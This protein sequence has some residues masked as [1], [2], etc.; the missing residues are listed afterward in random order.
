MYN[1]MNPFLENR[2]NNYVPIHQLFGF[3]SQNNYVE[4]NTFLLNTKKD[5]RHY[6]ETIKHSL[7]VSLETLQ[8]NSLSDYIDMI[9]NEEMEALRNMLPELD[10]RTKEKLQELSIHLD[11]V[12]AFKTIS[13]YY[14][15]KG[16][17]LALACEIN[18]SGIIKE[19]LTQSVDVNLSGG[20]SG[21]RPLTLAIINNNYDIIKLLLSF[22]N[23]DINSEDKI[24]IPPLFRAI[25][26]KQNDIVA[27]LLSLKDELNLEVKDKNTHNILDVLNISKNTEAI[28]ILL[29]SS[30]FVK[31]YGGKLVDYFFILTRQKDVN[32][33]KIEKY[34]K[35]IDINSV[36]VF[37]NT[38]LIYA[39]LDGNLLLVDN[40]LTQNKKSI[41]IT[42]S[43]VYG[44]NALMS[45]VYNSC[46]EG[47]RL[48]RDH[49]EEEK[50]KEM[51]NKRNKIG[52]NCLLLA[53]KSLQLELVRELYLMGSDVNC[54]DCYH[55][56]ALITAIKKEKYELID[57][58]L[59][60]KEIDINITDYEGM[61][62][63]MHAITKVDKDIIVNNQ[64]SNTRLITKLL[65]DP[66]LEINKENSYGHNVLLLSML[67][68]YEIKYSIKKETPKFIDCL[69]LPCLDL[70]GGRCDDISLTTNYVPDI[71]V[72]LNNY[73]WEEFIIS[74]IM[75]HSKIDLNAVDK[76]G[77]SA[78]LY[79]II[80]E[81]ICLFN[82][83][84]SNEKVDVNIKNKYD[85]TC[86]MI[87]LKNIIGGSDKIPTLKRN[88]NKVQLPNFSLNNV[89]CGYDK[90]NLCN[91]FKPKINER[92]E[93]FTPNDEE[94]QQT[95][96]K[97]SLN[98]YFLKELLSHKN[99]Y[100][101]SKDLF[102]NNILHFAA[103][104]N[105]PTI[106]EQILLKC[107][108]NVNVLDYYN[109]TP[110]MYA[111]RNNLWNNIRILLRN[112]ADLDIKDRNG[113]TAMDYAVKA[114][115]E[116]IL[117]NL[118]DSSEKK[119]VKGWFS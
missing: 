104:H 118:I 68:K 93:V 90:E 106:L 70:R 42:H 56:S 100:L 73:S 27:L 105:I 62:P 116:E 76:D 19:I 3:Y 115:T 114:G 12:E 25:Y 4:H 89:S 74:L 17:L 77:I 79:T 6:R 110:L 64:T 1:N 58:L 113:N 46:V 9:N 16:N 91:V 29:D 69:G 111:V 51:V 67:K 108:D 35:F 28:D 66:R 85:K 55:N 99:I 32:L 52:E 117:V 65:N 10:D 31:L 22:K 30:K 59:S 54:K 43:N 48:F 50:L 24:G 109:N 94:H 71:S 33:E 103:S 86:L 2:G 36:D 78:L 8:A 84:M 61:T 49:I 41:N 23:I 63:L 38:V 101:K 7:R 119:P 15:K 11:N 92:N 81:D 39:C 102:G 82:L 13:N 98:L 112:G 21:E 88:E 37:G 34:Y 83:L 40:I 44:L 20:T 87:I 75:E 47:L 14:D 5:N 72:S 97:E 53:A 45:I 60:C 96:K 95:L 18:S 107:K 26:N 57:F 80:N